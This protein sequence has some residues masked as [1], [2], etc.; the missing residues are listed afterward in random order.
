[1]VIL[2]T[3]FPICVQA[4][5]NWYEGA[6]RDGKRNG[7]GKFYYSDKGQ[8]YEGFW[9]EG[10]AKCGTLSDFGRDEAPTPTKYPIPQVEIL[11]LGYYCSH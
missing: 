1:M 6:W 4:N 9:V 11:T 2:K 5:G 3:D 10:V 7:T 8:V